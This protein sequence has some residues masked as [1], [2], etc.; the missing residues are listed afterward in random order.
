MIGRSNW[1]ILLDGD[2]NEDV[3]YRLHWHMRALFSRRRIY[4]YLAERSEQ[5]M[6]TVGASF[7]KARQEIRKQPYDFR[8]SRHVQGL[9]ECISAK[10]YIFFITI[11][12][13]DVY[14]LDIRHMA[15]KPIYKL[16][17]RLVLAQNLS[18]ISDEDVS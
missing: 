17:Q 5:G 14:I 6:R 12:G 16:L 18:A 10:P 4:N 1:L 7:V 11:R 9:R 15:R 13:L 3:K 2:R 8:K